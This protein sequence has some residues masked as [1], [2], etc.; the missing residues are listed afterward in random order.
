MRGGIAAALGTAFGIA[1][2]AALAGCSTGAHQATAPT[3]VHG[4]NTPAADDDAASPPGPRGTR[5]ITD[6]SQLSAAPPTLPSLNAQTLVSGAANLRP[7]TSTA[8]DDPQGQAD[9]N[10]DLLYLSKQHSMVHGGEARAAGDRTLLNDKARQ[11]P[12]FSYAMLNQTLVA[13]QDLE[14]KKLQDHKLPDELK[15]VILVAVMTPEGKLTDISV[16]QHSGVG[17]VDRIMIDACKKG[18][19]AMNPPP[20]ARAEDGTY[21]IRFQGIINNYSYSLQGDY[22]YITHIGLALL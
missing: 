15:P 7:Q 20:A 2:C 13:A 14:A 21:R 1:F 3:K 11:F 5:V 17:E 6:L 19:W 18:L 12:E 10:L 8:I 9:R 16:E 4:H 22:R